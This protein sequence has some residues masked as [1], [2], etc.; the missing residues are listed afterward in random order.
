MIRNRCTI[1]SGGAR[2]SR[3]HSILSTTLI[4]TA[5]YLVAG[6]ALGGGIKKQK[7]FQTPYWFGA[8]AAFGSVGNHTHEIGLDL[9]QHTALDE[10]RRR[11]STDTGFKKLI[12]CT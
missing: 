11:I 12:T 2:R 10:I 6:Q 4:C 7:Q 5:L 9:T 8:G 3:Q 1:A